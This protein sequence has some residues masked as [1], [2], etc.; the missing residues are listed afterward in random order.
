MSTELLIIENLK[1]M[2]ESERKNLEIAESCGDQISAASA[3][4]NICALLRNLSDVDRKNSDYYTR[5]VAM[6]EKKLTEIQTSG[7]P[8]QQ[9]SGNGSRPNDPDS[10]QDG[11]IGSMEKE[12]SSRIRALIV[13]DAVLWNQIGGLEEEKRLLKEAIFFASAS[14]E[15]NVK[16]PYL[17]NILLYGPPGTGKTTLA[18]AASST[19]SATFFNAPLSELVSRY[20]GDS[21]RLVSALF[22]EARNNAPS[23]IFLDEVEAL[24][25]NREDGKS[26]QTGVLQEF[27]RQMDGFT[28]SSEFVMVIAATNRP[29]VLD[30]AIISRFEKRI[31]VG[32]PDPATRI[33]I[34]KILTVKR[35][36]GLAF[37]P[38]T[39]QGLTDGFSGRDLN[40]LCSE[41]VRIMLR[42]ANA[43]IIDSLDYPGD[44]SATI[45]R[46]YRIVPIQQEDFMAALK[47]VRPVATKEMMAKFQEWR[48]NYGNN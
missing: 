8:V 42:R 19:L 38:V 16:V 24:L 26:G 14:P 10:Q 34:I 12:F 43:D 9:R 46:K 4:A 6:W 40:Y 39:L 18:R 15:I 21:E 31:Y 3:C 36:Y 22:K 35:G 7:R 37:D 1:G 17:R 48:E 5:L 45:P 41:A 27:L 23:L 44:N 30:S 25:G 47:K 11:M 32:M 2:I 13:K 33:D 29:W 20:L 28:G